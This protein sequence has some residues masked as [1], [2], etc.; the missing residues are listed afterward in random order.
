MEV[1]TIR[2]ILIDNLR[3]NKKPHN[4]SQ[5]AAASKVARPTIVKMKDGDYS[6]VQF[7]SIQ[8][9][10]EALGYEVFVAAKEIAASED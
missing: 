4:V 5:L 3:E 6:G 1:M 8:K 2:N 10:F 7:G 9:V